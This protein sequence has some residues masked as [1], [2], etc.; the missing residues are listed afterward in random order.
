MHLHGHCQRKKIG[1][2]WS[3]LRPTFFLFKKQQKMS[4]DSRPFW[5][6]ASFNDTVFSD[7]PPSVF[8]DPLHRN[9]IFI[10][11]KCLTLG[12]R[13]D[14]FRIMVCFFFFFR[15]HGVCDLIIDEWQSPWT[16]GDFRVSCTHRPLTR[17]LMAAVL[18]ASPKYQ[19]TRS[20]H[21]QQKGNKSSSSRFVDYQQKQSRGQ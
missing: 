10:Q 17:F 18:S 9:S 1:R 5:A 2:P 14:F 3:P 13:G 11:F 19:D 21:T 16:N 7:A 4:C 20:T 15:A 8:P 12:R 6:A